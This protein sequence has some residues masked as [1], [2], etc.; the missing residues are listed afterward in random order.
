MLSSCDSNGDHIGDLGGVTQKLD[1]IQEMGFTGIWFMPIMPSPSYHKYD[2]KDYKAIDPAYGTVEDFKTLLDEAHAR[3]I[4]VII[5][6]VI[7]HSSTQHE[8]F[9]VAS[10]YLQTLEDGEEPDLKE[11]PYVDYYHFSTEKVNSTYYK[12]AGTNY[13]YEGSFWDQMPDLNLASEALRGE[14]EDV[15]KF[16][17]DLGV[18]GFR[19]DAPLHYEENDTNFNTE[20]LNWFYE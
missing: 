13:Y 1:Y 8:W 15:A 4:H 10:A 16:W 7:N 18:D 12:L 5:D 3:G 11:C 20:T 2:V 17:I 9:Q 6:M 14:L 19:M